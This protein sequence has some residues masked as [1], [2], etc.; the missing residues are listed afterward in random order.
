MFYALLPL[1]LTV[2]R[3]MLDFPGNGVKPRNLNLVASFPLVGDPGKACKVLWDTFQF[4]S[5]NFSCPFCVFVSRSLIQR[6]IS[7]PSWRGCCCSSTSPQSNLR[8]S[9]LALK[10]KWKGKN[11]HMVLWRAKGQKYQTGHFKRCLSS[12][13]SVTARVAFGLFPLPAFWTKPFLLAART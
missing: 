1:L 13:I 12:S 5:R 6:S 8:L 9:S 3:W 11:H 10:P 2:P 4:L 7:R